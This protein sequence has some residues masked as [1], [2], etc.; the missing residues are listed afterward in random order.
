[1]LVLWYILGAQALLGIMLFEWAYS[2]W[3]RHMDGNEERD[4]HF[5]AYRRMDV[6]K[7]A[8]WKF[9]PGALLL[10]IRLTLF[11][12]PI[13]VVALVCILTRCCV[14]FSKGPLKRGCLRSVLEG[15][16][17]WS[18]WLTL[19]IVGI[20]VTKKEVDADYSEYLG[21]NYK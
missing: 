5:P 4:R 9:Y 17:A 18:F 2:H 11:V 12:L 13:S 14:D 8:R 1:M 6:H 15:L 20:T 3:A 10:P 16:I 19:L 21:P 7:F